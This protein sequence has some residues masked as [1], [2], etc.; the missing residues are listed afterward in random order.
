[1]TSL[2]TA[3]TSLRDALRAAPLTLAVPSVE[4][5]RR[6]RDEL[7]QQ[8]DDYLLPRLARL[9]A[10]M[11]AVLGGSTGAGKST[12]VNSLVGAT[13]TETGVL[14]PTTR[15]PVL[16]C[17]PDDVDAFDVGASG[18]GILPELPR[19]T[20]GGSTGLRVVTSTGLSPGVALLDSPDI[21]SVEVA[22]HDLAAQLLGAADLWLFVT[23]AARYADAVPWGHLARARERSVALAVVVNRVPTDAAEVVTGDLRRMLDEGGLEGTPIFAIEEAPLADGRLDRYALGLLDAWLT[24]LGT[25]RRARQQIVEQSLH[26]A[27][28]SL[29]PRI[30]RVVTAV[31]DQARAAE[32]LQDEAERRFAAARDALDADLG[33]GT[34][35]RDQVLQRF[36]EHL[37]TT[38]WMDRLQQGVGRARDRIRAAVRRDPAPEAEA[39]GAIEDHLVDRIRHAVDEAALETVESWRGMAG[40]EVVLADAPDDVDRGSPDVAEVAAREV[41]AW[42][43]EVLQLIRDRAGARM[44]LAR[45]LSLGV[46]TVGVALM[47]VVFAQTGG[48]TG[49]EA[50]V[51]G[52]TAAV[53]QALL[54]AIFGDG[55]VRDLARRARTDL[56]ARIDR[57]L[58]TEQDRMLVLL[59]GL[60]APADV[61]RIRGARDR[62]REARP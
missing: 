25:D 13:V 10:P 20:G 6:D 53:S 16:V 55:V 26:G 42:Q 22:H 33:A 41:E 17:H 18:E 61:E 60:A 27:L 52:G 49:G 15:S 4:T 40:G 21:D 44:T 35:L 24:G 9:D 32:R 50:A 30:D 43:A 5:G 54:T 57:I 39:R 58:D 3:L 34:L 31:E 28:Q 12:L 37:G 8:V 51:A 45:G 14:R 2:P 1:M 29:E 59:D 46:N 47:V 62:V 56:L 38:A 11:L 48:V 19:V 23:T 36:R 7:V